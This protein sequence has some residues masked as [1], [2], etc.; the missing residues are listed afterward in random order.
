M[1]RQ[2]RRYLWWKRKL[3]EKKQDGAGP[4]TAGDSGQ[5]SGDNNQ[6]GGGLSEA[7]KKKDRNK[8]ERMASRRRVRGGAPPLASGSRQN[9]GGTQI[10]G[11]GA[12]EG[13]A[14]M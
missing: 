6:A 13:I 3:S 9:Q 14:N 8:A 1:L 12:S 11:E 10:V 2:L 7:M 5:G 4:S